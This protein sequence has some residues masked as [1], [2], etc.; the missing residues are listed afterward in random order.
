[1]RRNRNKNP[2]CNHNSSTV[3]YQPHYNNVKYDDVNCAASK[4]EEILKKVFFKE[5]SKMEEARSTVAQTGSMI[6]RMR[7]KDSQ[8]T[9]MII[10]HALAES[11]YIKDIGA[12][13]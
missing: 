13:I 1:M 11:M 3:F 6:M 5:A 9:L 10:E 4:K 8:T 12:V 2:N 7:P